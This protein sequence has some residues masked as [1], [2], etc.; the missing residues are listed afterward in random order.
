LSLAFVEVPFSL[1]RHY[2]LLQKR[3]LVPAIHRQ[4]GRGA[5]SHRNTGGY[6]LILLQSS[7]VS[8]N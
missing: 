7:K 1:E 4:T 3:R 2:R 5:N 6:A 8:Q